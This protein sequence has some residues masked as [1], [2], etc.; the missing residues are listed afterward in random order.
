MRVVAKDRA[1]RPECRHV[2]RA[3][4]RFM[5]CVLVELWLVSACASGSLPG[6]LRQAASGPE[7]MPSAGA[8]APSAPGSGPTQAIADGTGQMT[9]SPSPGAIAIGADCKPGHYT[10]RFAGM[11]RTP[12]WGNGSVPVPF[13]TVDAPGLPGFEFWLTRIDHDCAGREFCADFNVEGGKVRGMASPF[14]DPN[15]DPNAAAMAM[16]SGIQVR[17]EI[18]LTGELDCRTGQ[19]KGALH[20]GCYD[21]FGTLYRFDGTISGHYADHAAALQDG[22]WDIVEQP[23]AALIPPDPDIGGEG[24]WSATWAD[25]DSSPIAA[26]MGL[27]DGQSGFDT[28]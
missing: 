19:F 15:L 16:A 22:A 18:D 13:T 3:P 2:S 5:A 27:C 11:Y 10:G 6:D 23:M 12:L 20:N 26:G 21:V 4:S 14:A 28:P 9:S 7:A 24:T 1:V 8:P 17:F 25:D